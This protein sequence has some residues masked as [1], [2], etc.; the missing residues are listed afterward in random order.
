MLSKEEIEAFLDDG[1][2]MGTSCAVSKPAV[3]FPWVDGVQAVS[4]AA[5][6]QNAMLR[7]WQTALGVR[8]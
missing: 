2:D 5:R 8:S 7:A 3:A 6:T 4:L 1:E